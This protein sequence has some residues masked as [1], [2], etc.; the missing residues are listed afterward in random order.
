VMSVSCGS[1]TSA[2]ILCIPGVANNDVAT[3]RW[4][5]TINSRHAKVKFF[6]NAKP[7]PLSR[8]GSPYFYGDGAASDL[9]RVQNSVNRI[10]PPLTH[11][12]HKEGGCRSLV[13]LLLRLGPSMLSVSNIS[14]RNKVLVAFGVVLLTAIGL[15]GFATDRLATVNGSAVEVRNNWLPATGW[16]GTLS[17][18]V[19]Q[20]RARHCSVSCWTP[21]IC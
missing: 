12:R 6:E 9:G 15:G 8:I 21:A 1:A 3:G 7:N 13:A 14:I 11:A 10:R 16:L 19:E 20:Y 2:D 17:K 4:R 5:K 18:S